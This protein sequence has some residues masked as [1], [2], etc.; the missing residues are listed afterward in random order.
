MDDRPK[1]GVWMLFAGI[2]LLMVGLAF[3]L[4]PLLGT[5]AAGL[6]TGALLLVAG[7]AQLLDAL[8]ERASGWGW[9]VALGIVALLAG[10]AMLA[11][12]VGAMIGVTLLL[13]AYLLV[14]GALRI[15]LAG[16]WSP[17]PGWGWMLFNGAI[18]LLLGLLI[19]S[20]WPGTGLWTVGVFLGV[21]A[22]MAGFS[23]VVRALSIPAGAD[24]MIPTGRV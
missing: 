8:V 22:I 7:G 9:S 10:I 23:R 19:L 18:S 1:P 13:A 24:R 20:G 5:V 4:V 11:D 14:A 16:I 15:V 12:P 3:L 2:L 21:D 6:A 17:V